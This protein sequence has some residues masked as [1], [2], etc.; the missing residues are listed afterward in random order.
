MSNSPPA[1]LARWLG[2]DR[3]PLRRT[4]DRVEAALRLIVLLGRGRTGKT[5]EARWAADRAIQAGRPVIL[6][7]GDRTNRSLSAFYPGTVLSPPDG[8]DAA[9]RQAN[10]GCS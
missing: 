9:Q 6:A 7:D 5:T 4:C 8:S 3:N 1:R 10:T 2:L